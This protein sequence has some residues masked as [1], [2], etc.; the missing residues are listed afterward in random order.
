M[1]LFGRWWRGSDED[2]AH[3]SMP[4][5][6]R[7][8]LEGLQPRHAR[9][10]SAYAAVLARIAYSDREVTPD[11]AAV[12]NRI[13]QDVDDVPS[14]DAELIVAIAVASARQIG[15]EEGREAAELIGRFG[16]RAQRLGLLRCLFA[17]AAAHNGVSAQEFAKIEQ[18]GRELGL[19][20]GDLQTCRV[21]LERRSAR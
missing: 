5:S 13:I 12:M 6:F 15:E 16:T 19:G 14:V 8:M 1:T 4:E 3:E 7:G 11:E 9:Y 10:L 21:D 17:V 2:A 18:I 20:P